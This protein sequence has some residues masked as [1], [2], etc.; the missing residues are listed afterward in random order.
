M[1]KPTKPKLSVFQKSEQFVRSAWSEH[2]KNKE[3]ID[4]VETVL[5][6]V[7]RA[8][9]FN[10]SDTKKSVPL[11]HPLDFLKITIEPKIRN[12]SSHQRLK[13]VQALMKSLGIDAAWCARN[14]F[15]EKKLEPKALGT[16]I[17]T[18]LAK[19]T[20]AKI[21]AKRKSSPAS[22]SEKNSDMQQHVTEP[23]IPVGKKTDPLLGFLNSAQQKTEISSEKRL[24][25]NSDVVSS[26]RGGV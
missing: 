22:L 1:E 15:D 2:A 3:G 25:H 18:I 14:K 23:K 11:G 9:T 19:P 13:Y 12:M 17:R 24:E 4:D 8:D 6:L 16:W 7:R 21:K 10:I 26:L 20:T 5:E